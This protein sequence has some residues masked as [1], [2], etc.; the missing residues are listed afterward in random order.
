MLKQLIEPEVWIEFL[1]VDA[2]GC[3]TGGCNGIVPKGVI[4]RSRYDAK[5]NETVWEYLM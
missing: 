5:T 1:R 4:V 2:Y 3:L